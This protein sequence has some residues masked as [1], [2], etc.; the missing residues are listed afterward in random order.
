MCAVVLFQIVKEL[1]HFRASPVL[2]C[3]LYYFFIYCQ[4]IF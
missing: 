1:F 2:M 4:T 3:S